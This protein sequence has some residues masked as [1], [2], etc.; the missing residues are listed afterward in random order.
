VAQFGD[1]YDKPV[2]TVPRWRSRVVERSAQRAAASPGDR[3][4]PESIARRAL[5]PTT[6]MVE[7]AL[8]LA[9]E[10]GMAS[11][12]VQ[13]VLARADVSL[14]TFYRHFASKDELLLAVIEE[15]VANGNAL[16]R[17][18]AARYDDPVVR[19]ECVVKGPIR[20]H[21][22][23]P[24][25]AMTVREHLRL[26]E[27]Y[28]RE[29]RE[30]DEPYHQLLRETIEAA[31]A[32]GCFPGVDAGDEAE[33]IM[34]LVLARYQN[35]MLGAVERSAGDEAEHLWRFV[36]GALTRNEKAAAPKRARRASRTPPT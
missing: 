9:E 32:A 5:K 29:V 35:V 6:R 1:G 20:D 4:T 27:R 25:S 10:S 33:L 31:Q 18:E 23:Q 16:Y 26:M 15:T 36:F 14:Q 34:A 22:N 12:T 19:L 28:A 21:L 3:R 30:A 17:R 24:T 2:S 7:A 11:F 13:D 8:E